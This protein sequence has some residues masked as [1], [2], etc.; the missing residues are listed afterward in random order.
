MNIALWLERAGQSHPDRAAVGHGRQVARSYRDLA[1]RVARLA[2][3]LTH[4]FGLIPGDRVAIVAKNCVEYVELLFAIWH[5]GMAAVPA[6]AKLHGTELGY[7][8][9][10]SGARACFA[11]PGLDSAIAPH[12]PPALERLIVI[13]SR[14]YEALLSQEPQIGRAHV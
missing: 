9:E 11:S 13:G 4:K 3:A 10:H 14:E 12:A 5:A 2:G 8:L 1:G 7:I 6:N